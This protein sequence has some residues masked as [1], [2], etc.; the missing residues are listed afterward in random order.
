MAPVNVIKLSNYRMDRMFA[1]IVDLGM[2][3]PQVH[4][5]KMS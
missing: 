3:P 5:Q 2:F 4:F 1:I